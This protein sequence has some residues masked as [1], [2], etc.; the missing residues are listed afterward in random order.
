M[1]F[2]WLQFPETGGVQQFSTE[3][4]EVWR[5]R[6]WVDTDEPAEPDLTKDPL[7][8]AEPGTA[9]SPTDADDGQPSETPGADVPKKSTR[10]SSKASDTTDGEK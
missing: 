6:G 3:S 1:G 9:P 8:H 2:V 10:K 7:P 5:A 4:A